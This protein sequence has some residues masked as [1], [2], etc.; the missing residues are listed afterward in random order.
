MRGR[1]F[2]GGAT[3]RCTRANISSRAIAVGP[4]LTTKFLGAVRRE[5]DLDGR[6]TEIL[7][8][9]CGG[10]LGHVFLGEGFTES[11]TRHC[12]NSVSM[13]FVRKGEPLPKV[14]TPP[15]DQDETQQATGE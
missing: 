10:H 9:N 12:V 1:I 4:V 8:E 5:T 3:R 14:I 2:V 13:S 15:A 7:C 11:N 6:R